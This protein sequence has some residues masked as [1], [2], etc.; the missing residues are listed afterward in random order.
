MHW[1]WI[2]KEWLFSGVGVAILGTVLAFLFRRRLA[3]GNTSAIRA[4]TMIGSPV[5]TGSNITQKVNITIAPAPAN[6]RFDD[7]S[8]R[9]T[10][11]EIYS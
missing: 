11:A 6:H 4:S 8:A 5:A 1:V 7:Y 9:P 10:P 3:S 2:N